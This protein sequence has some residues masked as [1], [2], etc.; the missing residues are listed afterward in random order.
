MYYSPHTFSI[1]S[2]HT[3]DSILLCDITKHH[4][5]YCPLMLEDCYTNKSC[6]SYYWEKAKD[7]GTLINKTI[8][9]LNIVIPLVLGGITFYF[10]CMYNIEI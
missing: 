5:K 4:C 9:P 6:N 7:Q 8:N 10:R 2:P 1:Q 3:Y